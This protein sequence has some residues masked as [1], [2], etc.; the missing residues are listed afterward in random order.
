[1]R[2][3]QAIGLVLVTGLLAACS[4]PRPY[5]PKNPH[6]R[7]HYRTDS[8]QPYSRSYYG[9]SMYGRSYTAFRPY[10]NY[11]RSTSSF[12]RSGYQSRGISKTANSRSSS[13]RGGFGGSGRVSASS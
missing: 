7:M 8:T 5:D 4:R 2:K 10:G 12:S 13:V 9:G 3:S 11:N 6:N 1:M